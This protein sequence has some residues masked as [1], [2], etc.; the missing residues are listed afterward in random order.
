MNIFEEYYFHLTLNVCRPRKDVFEVA[1]VYL[2]MHR[3][4]SKRFYRTGAR[5]GI[6]IQNSKKN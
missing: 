2:M 3:S 1:P 5:E 6:I 4:A